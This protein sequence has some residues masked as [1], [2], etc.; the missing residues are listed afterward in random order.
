LRR[1]EV[2][3]ELKN[4]GKVPTYPNRNQ[5]G[6]LLALEGQLEE[7]RKVFKKLIEEDKTLLSAHLNLANVYLLEYKFAMA[8]V[9]YQIAKSLDPTNGLIGYNQ[10]LSYLIQGKEKLALEKIKESANRMTEEEFSKTLGMKGKKMEEARIIK[11]LKGKLEKE[12][13]YP[14]FSAEKKLG[15]LLCWVTSS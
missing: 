9:E 8:E 6:V 7:A 10:T 12:V 3:K 11:F 15:Y 14:G 5:Q 4:L 2:E 13:F 1:E